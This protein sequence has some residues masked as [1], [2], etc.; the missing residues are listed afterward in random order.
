MKKLL[1]FA[2]LASFFACGDDEGGSGLTA[3]FTYSEEMAWEGCPIQ[4]TNTSVDAE[5]VEWDFGDGN[6]SGQSNPVHTYANAGTYDVTLTTIGPGGMEKKTTVTVLVNSQFIKYFPQAK[7]G[8][9]VIAT[10]DGGY[11]ISGNDA[12]GSNP[13]DIIVIKTDEHGDMDWAYTHPGFKSLNYTNALIEAQNGYFVVGLTQNS[14]V[15]ES[16]I[17]LIKINLN[18]TFGF[19][20]IFSAPNAKI[21]AE[22]IAPS[23]NG[24]FVV[25]GEYRLKNGTNS[26][27]L[28]I[29]LD[30]DGNQVGP[31]HLYGGDESDLAYSI[32][33]TNDGYVLAGQSR[34]YTN[35]KSDA[36]FVLLDDNLFQKDHAHYGG[37]ENEGIHDMAETSDGGIIALGFTNSFGPGT[38]TKSNMYLL[39]LRSNLGFQGSNFFGG[40]EKDSGASIVMGQNGDYVVAG[41]QNRA[42]IIDGEIS[43]FQVMESNLAKGWTQAVSGTQ[44]VS[45]SAIIQSH[46]CGYVLTG[47]IDDQLVLIKMDS[48]GNF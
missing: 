29:E 4:F 32:I 11:L 21:S 40:S 23:H 17:F 22:S 12:N 42:L 47:Q 18:G 7:L 14:T 15:T 16:E 35:G 44:S 48:E 20:K 43:F 31:N 3:S 37:A 38:P 46:D 30:K 10:S 13:V 33:K 26:D 9:D 8:Y 1:F 2:L 34:S 36:Y 41:I 6:T 5:S 19:S 27:I 28:V 25:A 45:A 39:Q 24:G